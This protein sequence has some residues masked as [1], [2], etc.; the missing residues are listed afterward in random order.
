MSI[1][2]THTSQWQP[3]ASL[4]N[5]KIRARLL[6]SIRAFFVE[7]NVLEVETP[8]LSP[9]AITDP[10]LESFSTRFQQRDYYLQTSPEFYMK[11]LLAAGSGDIYQLAR[12]F[13]VDESGRYHNPE[14]SLLEW[15]RSGL[16]HFQLMDEIESLLK[17]ILPKKTVEIQ[18]ISYRQ[19]FINELQ[20]DPLEARA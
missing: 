13:R 1:N 10:Q 12:V 11:R 7:R 20:L 2:Q 4:E 3:T 9:A 19:A 5:I 17:V 16:D 18:R 6:Q 15:Y 14:F 8:V